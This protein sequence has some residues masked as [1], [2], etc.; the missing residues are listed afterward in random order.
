MTDRQRVA[1][2]VWRASPDLV[3]ALDSRFGEPVDTYVNGSQ[4]WIREDGPG[5]ALVEWRLHPVAGYRR[6]PGLATEE[7]FAAVALALGTGARPPAPLEAL[8]DGLEVFGV[9][10]DDR[11]EPQPLAAAATE[12]LGLAPDAVGLVDHDTVG[13]AWERSRGGMSIVDALL[14]QLGG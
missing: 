14:G 9:E 5:G 13:D 3:V 1:S 6:P 8:W 4:V 12:V 2:C 11:I 7:V 10:P